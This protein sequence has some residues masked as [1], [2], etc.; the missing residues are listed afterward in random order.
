MNPRVSI[1]I[2]NWNGLKDTLACLESLQKIDYSNYEVIVVDNNSSGDDVK[3]LK[4]RF[5]DFLKAIIINKEN[6]GFSGGNNVGIKY[7]LQSNPDYIMLL[8]ND[9]IVEPDFISKLIEK[10]R[11]S[12]EIGI[13]TPRINY[14]Y[15]K[16]IIWAAGGYIS[17]FRASGFSYGINKTDE[18]YRND[19]YCTFASGCCM[20]IK[21]EVIKKVGMLDE[22]YFLYLED[23]DY[24]QRVL[25]A[26]YKILYVND[27][28]VYHKVGATTSKNNKLLP[29][30]YSVRNRLYFTKKNVRSY[31]IWVVIYLIIVFTI[32]I[33]LQ[34][35]NKIQTFKI[36][37]LAFKDHLQNEMGMVNYFDKEKSSALCA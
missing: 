23:T 29:M 30:Y 24:C 18:K 9:T 20:L 21:S 1:I 26:D 36:F 10:S 3:I 31:Y 11:L 6:L 7:A 27:S 8:N 2:L 4:Q 22:K 28:I 17:K 32:K 13:L 25:N 16:N 15:E 12:P 33:I 5:G 34:E 37:M 35:K 14:F 19:K